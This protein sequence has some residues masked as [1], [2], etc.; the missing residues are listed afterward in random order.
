MTLEKRLQEII[1][2][3]E[4][5]IWEMYGRKF[6]EDFCL[7]HRPNYDLE[8]IQ[9]CLDYL[10]ILRTTIRSAPRNFYENFSSEL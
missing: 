10:V 3:K 4:I 5:G 9:G 6:I 8:T 1:M 7:T 2:H